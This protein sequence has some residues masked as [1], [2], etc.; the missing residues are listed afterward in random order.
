MNSKRQTATLN[1]A[2]T[3]IFR[4]R[5]QLLIVLFLVSVFLGYQALQL[6]VAADF[7]RMVPQNHAYIQDYLPYKKL[8]GG[9]NHIKMEVSLKEGTIANAEFLALVRQINEDVMFIKGVDR[10]KVRSLI[11]PETKFVLI[12]EDGFDMGPIVPY[13]IPET[14][15]GLD[16]IENNITVAQLK[17]RMVSMDMKSVLISAEIYETGVDYLSVYHQLNDIRKKYSSDNISIHINGFAMVTGFVND[18]LPKILGLFALSAVIIVLILWWCF[19]RVSLAVLPLISAGL[20][21]LWSLGISSLIG[22]KLD[23]MTT[24]APFLV[25]AIGVS[26]G[27]QMVKRYAEECN[28]HAQGY[29]AALWSLSGLMVPGFVA[30]TTDVVGFLTILFVPILVIQDLAITASIGIACIIVANIIVLTLMLSFL[31]DPVVCEDPDLVPETGDFSH[32]LLRWA[33]TLTHGKNAYRVVGM[34]LVLLLI[35][36]AAGRTMKV[37]DVNPGE[38]LLWEDSTYNQDAAKIMKDFML[39]VDS[40]SV[41]VAGEE[42]GT[43]KNYD[44]IDIMDDYEWEIGHTPGVTFVISPL[45]LGKALNEV[46]HEGNLRWRAFPKESLELGQVFATAGSTDDSEL[47]SM[48]CQFMNVQIFLS[49]HKGDTIRRVIEKTKEFIAAHSLPEKTKMVLAGGNVGVMAATNE[50]VGDAQIPMLLLIYLSIFVLCTLIFRN[51]KAPCFIVAP[52]FL[53]SVLATA[54]MKMFGLG[55]N[56][57]TLPMASLG[58]GIGVDYGIYI[59]SRLKS[60]LES[61]VDFAEAVVR[62]LTSTGVAVFYAALTLSA[63]VFTWLLSDLKFQA[64]MGLLLGFLFLSNM[65]GALVL[66]PALVYIVDYRGKGRS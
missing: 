27:T 55:L 60:E 3:L 23:P 46:L 59:Y 13:K 5:I 21:V 19:R 62:T 65:I 18:A 35:G 43:C 14:K 53:V 36:L 58:V 34:C 12:T 47:M 17:G 32:R 41:V 56:V 2:A 48:G 1:R 8:F 16:K 15:A 44:T 54:F 50:E 57:N 63:G 42:E 10:L 66:L 51:L 29:N 20:A 24:M 38:P 4:L 31:S 26:H 22:M 40:L 7:S 37:G 45:M 33:A 61:Q 30:L 28:I 52:L 25:F 64:D 39:G 9:G 6:E 11:S 49:D